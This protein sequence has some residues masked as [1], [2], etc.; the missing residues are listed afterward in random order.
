MM[1]EAEGRTEVLALQHTG[2]TSAW[3][4]KRL[5]RLFGRQAAGYFAQNPGRQ[6]VGSVALIFPQGAEDM[7]MRELDGRWLTVEAT[8]RGLRVAVTTLYVPFQHAERVQFMRDR[9]EVPLVQAEN[10]FVVGDFNF[11]PDPTCPQDRVQT[12]AA[13]TAAAQAGKEEWDCMAEDAMLV[14]V[15]A[16]L[17]TATP[18][19]YQNVGGGVVTGT[20]L[21][22]WYTPAWCFHLVPEATTTPSVQYGFDHHLVTVQLEMVEVDAASEKWLV[23]VLPEV[24]KTHFYYV[25]ELTTAGVQHG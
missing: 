21:D 20:Q 3:D 22:R 24:L 25:E 1:I 4:A 19:H 15:A 6:N 23:T 16:V 8:V 11:V 7:V 13:A 18:T 2:I 14:D 5:T 9:L 10:W 12:G 17:G